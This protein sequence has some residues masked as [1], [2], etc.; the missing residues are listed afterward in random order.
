MNFAPGFARDRHSGLYFTTNIRNAARFRNAADETAKEVIDRVFLRRTPWAGGVPVPRGLKPKPFQIPAIRHVL[1]L[2]RSYLYADM[3]TGKGVMAAVAINALVTK[4]PVFACFVCPPDLVY[5]VEAE[6]RK[7]LVRGPQIEIFRAATKAKPDASIAWRDTPAQ[8]LVLPDTMLGKV[9]GHLARFDRQKFLIVDE[10]DRFKNPNADRTK[11]LFG[12]KVRGEGKV[13]GV[14]SF[15]EKQVYMSGTALPNGNAIELFPVLEF[16][17]PELIDFADYYK[18]AFEYCVSEKKYFEKDLREVEN[19]FMPLEEARFK[20]S[21]RDIKD[22]KE[23]RRR[24]YGRFVYRLRKD[25]LNLPPRVESALVIAADMP[26]KLEKLDR[27]LRRFSPEDLM[28]EAI[29]N[30]NGKEGDELHLMSYRRLLGSEKVGPLLPTIK[31]ILENES[32][33]I[34]ALHT[35][36]V[37]LLAKKLAR[38]DPVIIDGRVSKK[39]RHERIQEF[40][41][42]KRHRPIIAQQAAM[43][44]GFTIL[45]CKRVLH[46]EYDWVP[47]HNDQFSDRT[48]RIGQTEDVYI[49]YAVFRNSVDA[50]VLDAIFRKRKQIHQMEK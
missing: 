37:D 13:P 40:L 2:N 10:A 39:T 18:Y 38:Y 22:P 26:P 19:G 12:Y 27:G 5:N 42:D 44:R 48:H 3:G 9:G 41:K 36:V 20:W 35:E 50:G 7:W 14:A 33:L 29:A 25:N 28:R 32:L 34:G 16:A 45:K 17:A 8:V 6:L 4:G 30:A 23:F 47:G 1:E 43:R 31:R 24:L 11:N 15:F 21:F 49:Q 46:V